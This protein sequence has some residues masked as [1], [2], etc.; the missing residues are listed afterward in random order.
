MADSDVN[1]KQNITVFVVP[2]VLLLITM[3]YFK[4]YFTNLRL[5]LIAWLTNF[6]GKR[7]NRYL[8]VYKKELFHSL[9]K[10]KAT[11]G[12]DLYI[13]EIG[14]GG[15]VNFQYY[16][17]GSNVTCLDPNPY[18]KRHN[19]NNSDENGRIKLRG[20]V[21]GYAENMSEVE[22]CSYDVVV[23]TLVLCTARD[24]KQAVSEVRR[25]LK[26]VSI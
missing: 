23:S 5:R 9:K 13:L 8:H 24:P 18:C 6:I 1:I 15:G 7:S 11:V 2:F 4:T 19:E 17:P 20:F 25:I 14:A 12:D 10:L 22:D 21:K 16:P 3:F 26:F